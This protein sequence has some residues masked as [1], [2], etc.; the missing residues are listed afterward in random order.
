MRSGIWFLFGFYLMVLVSFLVGGCGAQADFT[1]DSIEAEPLVPHARHPL[2]VSSHASSV[3]DSRILVAVAGQLVT[4]GVYDIRNTA[5][6]DDAVRSFAVKSANEKLAFARI[7]YAWG[8]TPNDVVDLMI[9]D[10]RGSVTFVPAASRARL[11]SG[12]VRTLRIVGV[13]ADIGALTADVKSGDVASVALFSLVGMDNVS[14]VIDVPLIVP[15]Y[16]VRRSQPLIV[17]S[18]LADAVLRT[19]K[20]NLLSWVVRADPAGDVSVKQFGL[21]M[22]LTHVDICEFQ[23]RRNTRLVASNEISVRHFSVSTAVLDK[24]CLHSSAD[25]AVTFAKEEVIRAG[26]ETVFTLRG[27]IAHIGAGASVTSRFLRIGDSRTTDIACVAGQAL[28]LGSADSGIPAVL[29][30][31][32]SAK[33]HSDAP[34]HSSKDWIGDALLADLSVSQ[35]LK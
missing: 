2:R 10:V 33:P 30:S 23:L 17:A 3:G 27:R 20:L 24:G 34:C 32:L 9:P 26:T 12:S 14:A 13:T 11:P 21:R 22:E 8:E 7:G 31:D 35:L 15:S 29:W 4:L 16:V 19:D 18:P 5:A 25:L 1:V 28:R 6:R